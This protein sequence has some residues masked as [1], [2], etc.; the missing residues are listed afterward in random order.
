M[1]QP[2]DA[3]TEQG[4]AQRCGTCWAGGRCPP[5]PPAGRLK[6][7]GRRGMFNVGRGGAA[8]PAPPLLAGLR[9]AGNLERFALSVAIMDGGSG[10]A[11]LI[12]SI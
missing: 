8:P 3:L 5:A 4:T 2:K 7:V 1:E 11:I 12:E 6:F 10:G 9:P